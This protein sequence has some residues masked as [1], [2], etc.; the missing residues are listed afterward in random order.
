[1][2]RALELVSGFVTAPGAA[3]T[4]WTVAVGNSLQIRNAPFNTKINILA[5]WAFNQVAGVLRVRSPRLHD[6]VQGIRVRATTPDQ[7]PGW[8][9]GFKQ[10][11]IPQD[12]LTVEQTGSGVAGQIESGSLLIWYDD[13]PGI[14]GR[15]T[16]LETVLTKG[17][18]VMGQEVALNPGIAGGYSGQRA[19]NFSFDNWKANTDYAL[20]GGEVDVA[21]GSI[22]IQGVDVGNLG[23]GFPGLTQGDKISSEWF[24]QLARYTGLPCIPVF[25]AANKAAILVDTLQNQGGAAVN[26]TLY[27]IEL[28]PGTV[29]GAVAAVPTP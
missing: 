25:N 28:P 4:P 29:P 8:P 15:F 3:F 24:L 22:R 23:L 1:M 26:T 13:L 6:N 21:T 19:V 14:A 12:V 17:I 5:L 18:N 2:G 10:F 9:L 7:N 16:D 11:L 27:F 20:A